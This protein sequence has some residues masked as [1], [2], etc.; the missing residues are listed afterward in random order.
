MMLPLVP[1][2]PESAHRR[3][4]PRRRLALLVLAAL[5]CACATTPDAGS[6][7]YRSDD[8][9]VR[10]VPIEAGATPNAHPFTISRDQLRRLL[11]GI[12]VRRTVRIG[13]APVFTGDELD[14]IVPPLVA[15]LA[16]ASPRQDVTFAVSGERGFLGKLS[17]DSY[18]TGRLFA[19]D[20]GLN[21]VFGIVHA[22]VDIGA[23]EDV[24]ATPDM[25][26]GSRARR[27]G[28]T[29]WKIE[30]GRARLRAERGD[31][32]VFA[33]S[34]VPGGASP[35]AAGRSE[36][37]AGGAARTTSKAEEIANRLRVLD[38]LRASGAIT[39]QEY[40]ERRQAILDQL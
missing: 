5:L 26:P 10:L 20:D 7:V 34:A 22:Q 27:V 2:V 14:K 13:R 28:D 38:E 9:F 35:A 39:E 32:L 29:L 24:W 37:P 12:Q 40:R 31:W 36:A 8:D 11:A 30:P 19:R 4:C 16:K 33:R 18:T 17:R 25:V 6:Y 15:A 3:I 21:L 23:A 1:A